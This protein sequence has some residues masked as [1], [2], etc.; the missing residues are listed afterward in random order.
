MRIARHAGWLLL[1]LFTPLAAQ[2]PVSSSR[3]L[4]VPFVPTNERVVREMLRLGEVGPDDLVYDLG[5]GD[6][7]IVIAAA[8][9]FGARGV[10]VDLNPDRV[11]E[12]RDNAKRAGVEDK[13]EF[14]QG[15]L[16]E[17][18]FSAASVVT[19]YLLPSVNMKLRSRLLSELKPGTKVV[20]HAFDMEDWQPD[21]VSVVEG[22]T[23]YQWTVPAPVAGEW[24]W[25]T[26]QGQRYQVRLDQKFQ[27]LS[28]SAS[29]DGRPAELVEAKVDG[30]RLRLAI[31]AE[32][33]EQ[34]T[35]F[36][37]RF[38]D[39]KLVGAGE[40]IQQASTSGGQWVAE[41]VGGSARG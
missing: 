29:V 3:P 21:Q 23:V 20:S 16:F 17:T 7:R 36:A 18:D 27:K 37:A 40:G 22:T 41:R 39:G 9:D 11:A 31:K 13:V 33:S 19:M 6:G 34:P 1:L 15:D 10:G 12:A 38:Q 26:D 5:S 4:D 2:Q 30:D 32:G 8:K 25:Q 28:G 24:R 14:K 35:V